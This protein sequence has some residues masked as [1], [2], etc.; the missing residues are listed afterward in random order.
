MST[1]HFAER[2]GVLWELAGIFLLHLPH[3]PLHFLPLDLLLPLL[4]GRLALDHLV[5]QAAQR[6]PVGAEGVAFVFHHLRSWR[7]HG[8]RPTWSETVLLWPAVCSSFDQ[9]LLTHVS[10]RSHPSL[11]GLSLRYVNGQTQ[12]RYPDVAWGH[13]H[14]DTKVCKMGDETGNVLMLALLIGSGSFHHQLYFKQ[15]SVYLKFV[16]FFGGNKIL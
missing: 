11:D 16:I 1:H 8:G 15:D 9:R 10:H 5:Q 2:L 4:E 7:R 3:Q 14:V 12:V 13:K 6:P